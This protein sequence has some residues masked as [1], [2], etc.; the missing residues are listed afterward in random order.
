M[1]RSASPFRAGDSLMIDMSDRIREL[2]GCGPTLTLKCSSSRN[3]LVNRGCSQEL[4]DDDHAG[5][6]SAG[7]TKKILFARRP[8]K[9]DVHETAS[10]QQKWSGV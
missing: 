1:P 5:V 4:L 7:T 3:L 9:D 10:N 8:C 6:S 2:M